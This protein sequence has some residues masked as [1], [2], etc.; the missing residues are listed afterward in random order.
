MLKI[1]KKGHTTLTTDVET[2]AVRW[3]IKYGEFSSDQKEVAQF[4][5]SKEEAKDFAESLKRANKLLGHTCSTLT[6]VKCE[7]VTNIGL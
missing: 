6:W 4:F 5:T 2:W 3:N 7:R 1:F